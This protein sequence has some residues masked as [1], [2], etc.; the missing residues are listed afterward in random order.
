MTG[1][2]SERIYIPSRITDNLL[3]L[4]NDPS[5]LSRLA[6]T[7]SPAL[8]RA[9]IEGDFSQVDGAFFEEFSIDTHVIAP[10]EL[11]K[12]WLRFRCADWGSYYPFAVL[13][14][15]YV[16]EEWKT[17][18]GRAIPKGSLIFYR[19]LYGADE[20]KNNRGLKMDAESVGRLI[21]HHDGKDKIAYGVLDPK[22]FD[23][24]RGP[25][26]AE[27]MA[28]ETAGK[29]RFR[30]ADNRRTAREGSIGGWDALRTR[31]R[32]ING[33]P[34]VYFFSTCKNLIRTFPLA[35]HDPDKPED[36]SLPEAHLLDAA[37]YGCM[38]RPWGASA[39]EPERNRRDIYTSTFQDLLNDKE[40]KLKR[41][42][43][44]PV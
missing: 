11:P 40:R 27:R 12:H 17:P 15:A 5:Y 37:R 26:I 38:S 25:S 30:R 10:C 8:V 34:T 18:Q 4:K 16:G 22:A 3:L 2:V 6:Q 21:A 13:W 32:G 24:D 28:R 7:G 42:R 33:I 1:L 44:E 36:L 43:H 19:E 20:A 41:R 31:L 35:Q 9:W 14:V 23:Q 39:P 29:V